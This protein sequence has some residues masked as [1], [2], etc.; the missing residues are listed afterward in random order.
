MKQTILNTLFSLIIGLLLGS[1]VLFFIFGGIVGGL[2][3]RF[4]NVL[5]EYW[6]GIIVFSV[7]LA[8]PVFIAF[9]IYLQMKRK[10]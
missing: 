8:L 5:G 9:R 2:F 1:C 4:L 6:V 10:N 7:L 3:A